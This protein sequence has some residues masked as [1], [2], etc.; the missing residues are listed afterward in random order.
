M[1]KPNYDD[2]VRRELESYREVRPE[3]AHPKIFTYWASRYL[4]PRLRE[5]MGTPIPEEFFAIHLADRLR[6]GNAGRRIASLGCGDC[7]S[8]IDVARR[9]Q[10]LGVCEF[11]FDCFDLSEHVLARARAAVENAGLSRLIRLHQADL[12]AW[13]PER[14]AYAGIMVNHALHHLVELERVFDAVELALHAD[15][16][17]VNSDMIGRNG[18][19]RWPEALAIVQSIWRFLPSRYKYNHLLRRH[20]EE[21]VNWDCSAGTLE[22][23]R[24]QD[25]LP[26]L[27]RRLHFEKFVAFGNLPDVFVERTF[28]PNLSVENPRDTA[29]VD[30]LEELNTILID[31]GQLKPTQ[32]F[33]V[34]AKRA[35]GPTLCDRGWTPRYCVRD[36]ALET[37]RPAPAPALPAFLPT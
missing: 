19:L 1:R 28:G 37:L 25:I 29:F 21:F 13:A 24:A 27:V 10:A 16:V 22:G 6:R 14:G 12:N 30:F 17:L 35:S 2:L 15:G 26:L 20:E 34:L 7:T 32:M 33:A 36:P 9:I 8:E 4:S 18:H 5:I 31:G 23:I 3:L 11:R